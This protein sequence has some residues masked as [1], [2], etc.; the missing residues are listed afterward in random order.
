MVPPDPQNDLIIAHEERRPFTDA[1]NISRISRSQNVYYHSNLLCIHC[2]NPSFIG[3]DLE[4]PE[5]LYLQPIHKKSLS[6]HFGWH[7]M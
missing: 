4:V 5:D 2:Q 6:G 3:T 1:K 7:S